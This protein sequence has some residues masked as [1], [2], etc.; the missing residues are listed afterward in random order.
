MM[1]SSMRESRENIVDLKGVTAN[2]LKIIVDF[3][4]TGAMLLNLQ[5][6]EDVLAAASHLQVHEAIELCSK[7][8]QASICVRNCVDILNI[9]E[10]YSL[11]SLRKS[12][13]SFILQHFE[14]LTGFDQYP[15]LNESQMAEFLSENGLRV[16][17][18]FTLF[19][20]VLKWI[21]HSPVEREQY[22]T[23]LM[24]NI[25][26]PLLSGEELVEKVS[27]VP[28]MRRNAE[29]C[30]LLTEA[31]D[32]HIVVSKQPLLQ[33]NRTQVRSTN[34]CIVICHA[35]TLENYS[36]TTKRRGFLKENTVALYNPSVAVVDNF[37][38]TC[39]GKYEGGGTTDIAMARCFRYDPRFDRW[40]ELAPMNEPRKDFVLVA[41]EKKLYAIAGQDEN[42]VMH[43]IECYD[44]VRNEW[45]MKCPLTRHVFRHAGTVCMGKIYIS[46]GQIFSGT[47]RKL[48]C[49]SPTTDS[50]VEK[51]PMLRNRQDHIMT[52]VGG[53]LYVIGGHNDIDP[54]FIFPVPLKEVEKYCPET[55]QWTICKAELSI[56]GAGACV[57][58]N[59]IYIVG[60]MERHNSLTNKIH[61]YDPQ[62][63]EVQIED[64][65]NI[66][67]NGCACALLTLPYYA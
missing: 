35:Q 36:L 43:T 30:D 13:K 22:V 32:Y 66:R 5:N 53:K 17:S 48:F 25:R 20:L 64:L 4:Y 52:E 14:D 1:K 51:A 56:I 58:D 12:A 9:A 18:E 60:G 59:T 16:M 33:S 34:Q 23:D 11:M 29:C 24:R 49:Y 19:N 65:Y 6:V 10:L 57:L 15:L 50:W 47:W 2:G 55:N 38:Y 21:Q 62:K 46:G 40:F 39:G 3:I 7:Y 42:K 54:L 26:L 61:K 27:R 41:I 28:I 63:D 37:L 31:K 8:L 45:E 67:I 44:I